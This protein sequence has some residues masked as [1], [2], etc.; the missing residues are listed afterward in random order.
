[1]SVKVKRRATRRDSPALCLIYASILGLAAL[2]LPLAANFDLAKESD[3]HTVAG[4]VQSAPQVTNE[5]K[6]GIKLH[7][8]IRG[9]EGFHHLIQD[10]LSGDVPGIMSLL[11]GD[12]VTARVRRDR[13]GRDLDWLWELKRDGNTIL[14]YQQTLRYLERRSAQSRAIAHW[15]GGLSLGLFAAAILLRRHFGAWRNASNRSLPGSSSGGLQP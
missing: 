9:S 2:G 7:I 8:F 3:L 5:G 12:D 13:L 1:M 15:A 6:S 4:S 10:D 14:S 11:P